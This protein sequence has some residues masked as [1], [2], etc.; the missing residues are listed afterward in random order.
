M[1]KLLITGGT[2]FIGSNVLA[3]INP[4]D[5]EVFALSTSSNGKNHFPKH[6]QWVEGNLLNHNDTNEVLKKYKPT[7]LLHLAWGTEPSNYNLPV[8][9]DWFTAGVNLLEAFK[10]NQGK[11]AVIAGS[12]VEYNWD[13][14][15]CKENETP[16]S[17]ETIYGAC[18]NMLRQY[19]QSFLPSFEIEHVWPRLFFIYGPGENPLRLVPHIITQLLK[20]EK[21]IVRSGDL[22][23]DYIYVKDVARILINMLEGNGNGTINVCAGLPFKIKDIAQTIGDILNKSDLIEYQTQTNIK[24]Q[25]VVGDN[26]RLTNE[27]NYTPSIDIGQNL[28]ETIE[29]WKKNI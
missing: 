24:R 1:K 18:K 9:F 17:H 6:I 4:D 3:A 5:F 29:W 7:H 11:R 14:G 20:N 16:T 12:G 2:G 13:Y 26:S 25:L 19:T 10:N 22:Y 28:A 8:N 27:L 15:Y 23:R 21:A